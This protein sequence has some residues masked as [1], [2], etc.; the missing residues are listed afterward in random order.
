VVRCLASIKEDGLRHRGW[1]DA[2]F[3]GSPVLNGVSAVWQLKEGWCWVVNA[4]RRHG[5]EALVAR[6]GHGRGSSNLD[7]DWKNISPSALHV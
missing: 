4:R 6:S 5:A 7:G 1:N 2:G 3:G